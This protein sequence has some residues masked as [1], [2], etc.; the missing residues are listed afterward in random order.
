M[1]KALAGEL[2]VPSRAGR[3][4]VALA[5]DGTVRI[6]RF[7]RSGCFD[8]RQVDLPHPQFSVSVA[9]KRLMFLVSYLES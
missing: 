2:S 1:D 7:A 6:E 8:C 5:L 4:L 9:S 3:R